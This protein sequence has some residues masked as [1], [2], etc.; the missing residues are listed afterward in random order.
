VLPLVAGAG[1]LVTVLALPTTAKNPVIGQATMANMMVTGAFLAGIGLL[2]ALPVAVRVVADLATRH[3]GSVMVRLAARR[4][5][6]EPASTVRTVAGLTIAVFLI[7]GATGV[8]ATFQDTP[9]YASARQAYE[10]GPQHHVIFA[11]LAN[12]TESETNTTATPP[13][14]T[15]SHP[16][17]QNDADALRLT[18]ALARELQGLAGVQ[19]VIPNYGIAV[20]G[21]CGSPKDFCG[22]V[23]VGTCADL[24]LFQPMQGCR[25]DTVSIITTPSAGMPEVKRQSLGL[26]NEAGKKATVTPSHQVLVTG[27]KAVRSFTQASLFIP[28]TTPQIAPLLGNPIAFDVLTGPGQAPR[29]A[30]QA[31]ADRLG[32]EV[33]LEDLKVYQEVQGYQLLL[34]TLAVIV[35]GIGLLAVLLTTIDRAIERRRQ[36]AGQVALGVPIRVLRGSQLLQTLVPLWLGLVVAVGL[37][38]LTVLAYLK[39]GAADAPVVAP[40]DTIA[41]MAFAALVGAAVVASATL[42]GIGR[43]LTPDL[44]RRE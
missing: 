4:L 9:L 21:G 22:N 33:V 37:G 25:D 34:S 39:I 3:S 7:T 6:A 32:V 31:I 18:K 27:D 2:I 20:A 15:T 36:V 17:S 41:S 40:S 14:S 8:L 19:S 26:A 42:P 5:Q 12:Q 44:L 13:A 28:V 29:S 38:Y 24:A 16:G 1:V 30:I 11:R 10:V 23:F 35:L 43:R